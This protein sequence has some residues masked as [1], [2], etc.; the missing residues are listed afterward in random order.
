MHIFAHI[1]S[2]WPQNR[3][4][5]V[6]I[7][8]R[9]CET[10]KRN[11][12]MPLAKDTLMP[13]WWPTSLWVAPLRLRGA[14][15][16]A[17]RWLGPVCAMP[18]AALA[19]ESTGRIRSVAAMSGLRYGMNEWSA[20]EVSGLSYD[21]SLPNDTISITLWFSPQKLRPRWSDRAHACAEV[22]L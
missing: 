15:G 8:V 9:K 3:E 19:R 11:L 1:N 17:G 4:I 16:A 6:E 20:D 22:F 14:A 2:F 5:W 10:A 21:L 12:G 18:V 7:W 13:T